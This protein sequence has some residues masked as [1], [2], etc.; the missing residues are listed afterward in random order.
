MF[1]INILLKSLFSMY[2]TRFE[3]IDNAFDENY[4]NLGQILDNND[5][6]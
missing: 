3:Y 5:S 2:Y 6:K 1:S 4:T